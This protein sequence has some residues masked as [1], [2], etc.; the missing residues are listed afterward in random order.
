MPVVPLWLS[1]LI[2]NEMSELISKLT[3]KANEFDRYQNITE[4][5]KLKKTKSAERQISGHYLMQK[6]VKKN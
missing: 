4:I 3:N 5:E 1:E 6:H 2:V